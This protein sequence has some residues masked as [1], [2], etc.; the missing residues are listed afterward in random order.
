[1]KTLIS[2]HP[3]KVVRRRCLLNSTTSIPNSQRQNNENVAVLFDIKESLEEV[4]HKKEVKEV[5]LSI[6]LFPH[7]QKQQLV[8]KGSI[9]NEGSSPANCQYSRSILVLAILRREKCERMANGIDSYLVRRSTQVS[10]M[11]G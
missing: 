8:L 1:M 9:W 2:L 7:F 10:R 6:K 11:A 4:E 5:T 3:Q